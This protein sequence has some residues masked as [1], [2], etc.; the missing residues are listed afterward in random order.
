MAGWRS[1]VDN[2]QP[3]AINEGIA[4]GSAPFVCWLNSD[5]W[6]LPGGL[7]PSALRQAMCYLWEHPEQAAEMGRRAEARYWEHFTADRMVRSYVD[8]YSDLVKHH[9]NHD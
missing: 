6:F 8:L 5:D 2:G 1:R 4:L 9:H 7:F 3:S